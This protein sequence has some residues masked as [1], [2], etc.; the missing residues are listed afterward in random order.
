LN[1]VAPAVVAALIVAVAVE[2]RFEDVGAA[3]VCAVVNL[4]NCLE[5][6]ASV[7]GQLVVV[8]VFEE[9]KS[10]VGAVGGSVG[11]EI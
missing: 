10:F 5:T 6:A 11:L 3:V 1:F 7:V 4:Q 9:R 2:R 8:V